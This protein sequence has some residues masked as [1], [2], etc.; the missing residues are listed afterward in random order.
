ML[1][2]WKLNSLYFSLDILYGTVPLLYIFDNTLRYF[3]KNI[4]KN[5]L[6]ILLL[7]CYY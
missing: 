7:L 6:K 4:V 1:R 2:K 5:V 3:K